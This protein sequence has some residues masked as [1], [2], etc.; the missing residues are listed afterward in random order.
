MAVVF[1]SDR[2]I[3][4]ITYNVNML[5]DTR[6][7]AAQVVP[8]HWFDMVYSCVLPEEHLAT[9]RSLPRC[10]FESRNSFTVYAMPVDGKP[11]IAANVQT[12]IAKLTPRVFDIEVSAIGSNRY[13]NTHIEINLDDKRW[14]AFYAEYCDWVRG[15]REVTEE[16]DNAVLQARKLIG[17]YKTLAPAL[18]AWPALWELIPSDIQ[19][20]HKLPVDRK[21]SKGVLPDDLD[22]TSL[23]GQLAAKRMGSKP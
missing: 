14:T 2:L 3:R 8:T 23:T 13:N 19:E 12:P 15:I 6:L 18:K 21:K 17:T 16:R 10:Y 20:R 5:F 11:G 9:L 22:L 7:K 1:F 4:D